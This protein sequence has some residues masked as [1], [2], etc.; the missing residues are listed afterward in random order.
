MRIDRSYRRNGTRRFLH[1]LAV[2]RAP[3]DAKGIAYK[4]ERTAPKASLKTEFA[5]ITDVDLAEQNDRHRFVHRTLPDAGVEP[6]PLRHFTV[7]AA[8]LKP[9]IQ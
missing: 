6:I 1:T 9:M 5:A 4:T 8:K 2:S 7:W 3:G